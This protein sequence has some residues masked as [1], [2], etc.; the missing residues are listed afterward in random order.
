M[1]ILSTGP[2]AS[3]A[4]AVDF[5]AILSRARRAS[6]S[7][8]DADRTAA[9]YAIAAALREATAEICR[10]NR[11]DVE[12]ERARGTSEALV[13]RLRL[14]PDRVD[15]IAAAVE[16]VATLPDPVGRTLDGRRLDNGLEVRKVTVP[17][18][19][20]GMIYESRPNVTVDAA[21]LALKAGSA[22]VLR[23][24]ANALES[25]RVLVAAMRGALERI[26]VDPD[27]IQL[28]ASRDR[29]YVTELL[30]ARGRVDL[31]IPRGGA[32][33]IA[34][35]VENARVPVIETGVG[36][37]HVFVDASADLERAEAI[38]LNAKVQRPGVCNAPSG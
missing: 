2:T 12:A 32:S 4:D 33:L 9:L 22:A 23:G 37:C 30:A 17:F 29:R 18:G 13:D 35:V 25:N 27:A 34:H 15:Q 24:S 10:A 3:A 14:D 16:Q 26:G 31:V 38:V 36:N 8:P 7:L 19:V 11:A 20:I 21:A 6:R 28:I 1:A 5:D